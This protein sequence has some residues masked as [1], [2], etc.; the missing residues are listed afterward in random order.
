MNEGPKLRF[1]KFAVIGDPI[2]HSLSPAMHN[3]AFKALGIDAIYEAVHVK[4]C[5][6]A[7]FAER[8][9]GLYDG[10]NV[11]VPH[12]GPIMEYLDG[13]SPVAKFAGSV[14][15]IANRDGRLFGESTDGKGLEMAIKCDFGLPIT[16]KSLFF[17][18]CGG[19][20]RAA[21]VH[22]ASVGARSLAFVNRTLSKAEDLCHTISREFPS[23]RVSC[24]VP[25]DHAYVA[26]A[27][28]ASEIIIQASS[29]G[30]KSGDPSPLAEEFF[31]KSKF[32][33][34]MIYGK[35][36]FLRL[37]DGKGCKCS[38]GLSMLAHQGAESFRIWTGLDAP[39]ESMKTALKKAKAI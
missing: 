34:D 27:V 23:V 17:V 13:V 30:L 1:A 32:Y 18:G 25:E 12:K 35:T 2:G 3:A 5:D 36:A 16:G 22:F 6:L 28:E 20:C 24:S 21:A 8:A 11:T 39:V 38:D 26:E 19:A 7:E 15:T 9:R 14:N 31:L 4:P 33:Y 29:L 37:A 10:V